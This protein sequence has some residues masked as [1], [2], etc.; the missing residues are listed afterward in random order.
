M[1]FFGVGKNACPTCTFRM[2][3][4]FGWCML[5]VCV[6]SYP[7]KAQLCIWTI[8]LLM[9]TRKVAIR[10]FAEALL[11]ANCFL[12]YSIYKPI[13][14]YQTVRESFPMNPGWVLPTGFSWGIRGGWTTFR[15]E[16]ELSSRHH[17]AMAII[18]APV[19]MDGEGSFFFLV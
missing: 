12:S 2:R 13:L 17:G 15:R 16:A 5:R 7:K 19:L 14:A 18:L 9:D 1:M 8:P 3:F 6:F 4:C 11:R 10:Y